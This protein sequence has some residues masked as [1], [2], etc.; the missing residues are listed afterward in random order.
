MRCH[1]QIRRIL[2]RAHHL[3]AGTAAGGPR[4]PA[5]RTEFP[6]L[7]VPFT[8]APGTT[9]SAPGAVLASLRNECPAR[10][11][12]WPRTPAPTLARMRGSRL[13]NSVENRPDRPG[14]ARHS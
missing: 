10:S 11:W 7:E 4:E 14:H 12:D 3:A 6:I 13:P 1:E 5:F 8:Q 2:Q 9:V